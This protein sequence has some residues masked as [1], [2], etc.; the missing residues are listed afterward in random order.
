MDESSFSKEIINATD[1]CDLNIIYGESLDLIC[2]IP[3]IDV[4]MVYIV[5]SISEDAVLEA[6]RNLDSE[7]INRARIIKQKICNCF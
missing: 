3:G 2:R 5:D 6:S 7:Y 4:V 1:H